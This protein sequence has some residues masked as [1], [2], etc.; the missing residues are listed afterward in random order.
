MIEEH[1]SEWTS[2][3]DLMTS[4]TAVLVIFIVVV[5]Q[6]IPKPMPPVN[7]TPTHDQRK[8]LLALS[9]EGLASI[10]SSIKRNGS[11]DVVRI[12]GDSLSLIFEDG[13]FD[14]S[15]PCL[16]SKLS[17]SIDKV[18]DEFKRYLIESDRILLIEGFTDTTLFRNPKQCFCDSKNA[19]W[20][21][22][23]ISLS[24]FRALEARR[25][26]TAGWDIVIAER[27]AIAGFGPTKYEPDIGDF[28]RRVI[29]KVDTSGIKPVPI[30][31]K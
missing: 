25:T 3:T 10:Y 16:T 8:D 31:L 13:A 23:N 26:L 11:G 22:D 24:A 27:V 5:I 6:Q 12:A 28:N 2:I 14:D 15:K 18:Q 17:G 9:K 19:Y 30:I 4:V 29:I 20:L 1:D 7:P 21:T